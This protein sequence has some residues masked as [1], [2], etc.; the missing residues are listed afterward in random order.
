MFSLYVTVAH[1]YLRLPAGQ[2]AI[3]PEDL[4]NEGEERGRR[5]EEG[6][7]K[8]NEGGPKKNDGVI[9]PIENI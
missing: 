6:G 5:K 3:G 9:K 7:P 8:R 1:T 4:L 2:Y